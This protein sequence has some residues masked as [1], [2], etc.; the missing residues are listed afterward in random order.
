MNLARTAVAAALAAL[1]LSAPAVPVGSGS[2]TIPGTWIFDFDGGSLLPWPNFEA[3]DVFWEFYTPTE[4]SLNPNPYT[5]GTP[6]IASVGLVDFSAVGDAQLAALTYG[7]A[8][9]PG[10]DAVNVLVPGYVF[11]V[12]TGEGNYAKAQVT[13]PF[14]PSQNLGLP[15][16][17]VTYAPPVPEPA[18]AAMLAAGLAAVALWARRR[19]R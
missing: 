14:D 12:R 16:Q 9:L 11:A 3:G 18:P 17:W 19:R 6:L 13:G 8:G 4:R 1:S 7:S 2:V 10:G 5:A 15:I